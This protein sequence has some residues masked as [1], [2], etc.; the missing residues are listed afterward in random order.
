MLSS[1]MIRYSEEDHTLCLLLPSKNE[2]FASAN[3]LAA[4]DLAGG[5][6]KFQ[7]NLLGGLGLLSEDWLGLT[8]ET[9]LLGIVAAL[10]LSGGGVTALLVLGDLV[11]L[12][13]AALCAVCFFLFRS[14]H[15]YEQWQSLEIVLV[16]LCVILPFGSLLNNI[17]KKQTKVV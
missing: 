6:L 16:M 2:W 1:F 13:L 5:A 12:M 10:T 3:D 7:G 8:T 4:T 14:M 9:L 17:N 15:L 11:I